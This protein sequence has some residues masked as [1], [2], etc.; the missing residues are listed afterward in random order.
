MTTEIKTPLVICLGSSCFARGNGLHLPVVQDYLRGH[1][2]QDRVEL[3]GSRCEGHCL[4]G[5]NLRVGG[6]LIGEVRGE[7]LVA[8][9]DRCLS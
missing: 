9:L 8:T 2:L 4:Q 6:E 3:S 5:P 7:T 1:E